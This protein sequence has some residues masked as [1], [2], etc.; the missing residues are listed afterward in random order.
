[1]VHDEGPLVQ[2]ACL[3]QCNSGCFPLT[4]QQG[5]CRYIH[6][7][8]TWAY[9]I[10]YCTNTYS[11]TYMMHMSTCPW[12]FACWA[13][14]S[15]FLDWQSCQSCF[16]LGSQEKM[17]KSLWTG[18]LWAFSPIKQ[19]FS[20]GVKMCSG[21]IWFQICPDPFLSVKSPRFWF[22][23]RFVGEITIFP[24]RSCQRIMLDPFLWFLHLFAR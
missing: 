3:K 4:N 22:K 23:H 19:L 16:Y 13:C 9:V 21:V 8:V 18:I 7:W 2:G 15:S 6:T 5:S 14:I 11:M 12:C 1:M 20:P 10:V 17:I 24:V